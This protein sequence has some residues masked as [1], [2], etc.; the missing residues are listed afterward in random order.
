MIVLRGGGMHTGLATVMDVT[1]F[2]EA[3]AQTK[4]WIPQQKSAALLLLTPSLLLNRL[5]WTGLPLALLALVIGRQKR[6]ALV[7]ESSSKAAAKR[8]RLPRS[9]VVAGPALHAETAQ[10]AEIARPSWTLAVLAEARFALARTTRGWAFRVAAAL[11]TLINVGGAFHHLLGHAEGPFVPRAELLAPFLIKLCY[12][13]S[14]FA[15]AG[16]VGALARDDQRPGFEEILDAT[17]APFRVRILGRAAA[18]LVLT[19]V[20]ALLP[21]LSAWIVIAIAA[22]SSFEPN[23]ALLI[24]LLVAAPA[25]LEIGAITFFVHA[26]VRASGTAH[27]LSMLVAFMTIVNYETGIVSYPPGQIGMPLHVDL[28]E[29]SGWSPWLAPV[30]EMAS[31]KLG[32]VALAVALA[33]W[34]TPRG[35]I[36][37]PLARFREVSKRARGE[38]GLLAAAAAAVIVLSATR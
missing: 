2:G 11:W 28:S 20:L 15:V 22:P 25:L 13:F 38:A 18:A 7:L 34:V 33:W 32:C 30:L 26:L 24:N 3:E 21:T 4:Q 8:S 31:L 1:G 10:R 5:L 19:L 9:L 12:V 16:F 23:N 35:I 14:V 27:A 17:P 36:D 29:L 37:R 6:E